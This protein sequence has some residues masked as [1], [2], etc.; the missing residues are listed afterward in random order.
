M[1]A[2]SKARAQALYM[3]LSTC[4]YQLQRHMWVLCTDGLEVLRRNFDEFAVAHAHSCV[5]P[6]EKL[7]RCQYMYFCPRKASKLT[8]PRM[9]TAVERLKSSF[10]GVS[11]CTFTLY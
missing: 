7:L 1:S 5:Q 11:I 9:H 10:S 4:L 6:T 8:Q 3:H 2:A